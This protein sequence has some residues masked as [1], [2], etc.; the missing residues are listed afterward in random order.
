MLSVTPCLHVMPRIPSADAS[1]ATLHPAL[2]VLEHGACALACPVRDQNFENRT[3][4]ASRFLGFGTHL[5]TPDPLVRAGSLPR[6]DIPP[7]RSGTVCDFS[8]RVSVVGPD[9]RCHHR[10]SSNSSS[11]S[12]SVFWVPLP[13]AARRSWSGRSIRWHGS[14]ARVDPESR[15]I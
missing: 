2:S 15:L 10:R 11:S 7:E 12:S 4:G 13:G 14:I 3:T 9:E 8:R 6:D 5:V 1:P